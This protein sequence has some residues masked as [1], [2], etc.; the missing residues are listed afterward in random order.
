M[1]TAIFAILAALSPAVGLLLTN[2]IK[3][4]NDPVKQ[5]A[6]R[7]ATIDTDIAKRD[8]TRAELNATAD[9]DQLDRLQNRS[10]N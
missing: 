7:Y 4:K 3:G 10:G 9:L 8:S 5:N 6:N 1:I 2:W